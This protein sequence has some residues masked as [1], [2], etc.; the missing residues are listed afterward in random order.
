M[1]GCYSCKNK[2]NVPGD[3]HIQCVMPDPKVKGSDHGIKNGWFIYPIC[4]DPTWM[5]NKCNNYEAKN[6]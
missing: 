5:I 4:F 1:T 2:R 6:V 3:T